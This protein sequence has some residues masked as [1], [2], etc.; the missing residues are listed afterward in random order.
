MTMVSNTYKTQT[1]ICDKDI[2][3][4]LV[5]GFTCHLKGW[6]DNLLTQF[7]HEFIYKY[8]KIE[9]KGSQILNHKDE[10]I[11]DVVASLTFAMSKTFTS[12]PLHLKD[13]NSELLSNLK[14]KKMHD[15]SWYKDIL[16]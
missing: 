16:Q 1:S 14:C 2:I 11:K 15:F 7:N 8:V 9:S 10:S 13:K 3:E 4:L 6:C 12:D 5:A